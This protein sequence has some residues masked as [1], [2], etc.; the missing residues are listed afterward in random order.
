MSEVTLTAKAHMALF[1]EMAD[2]RYF[3]EASKFL[4]EEAARAGLVI[5]IKQP[6]PLPMEF[7]CLNFCMA[8][9]NFLIWSLHYQQ[10]GG[11]P[12][13]KPWGMLGMAT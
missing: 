2:H 13:F 6:W 5:G 9:D 1:H 11:K 4:S 8:S 10:L 7:G 3:E 12:H